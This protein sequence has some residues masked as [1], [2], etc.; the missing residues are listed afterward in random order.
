VAR[1]ALLL[2]LVV[3]AA[4]CGNGRHSGV[5]TASVATHAAASSTSG[6]TTATVPSSVTSTTAR[7][8][9]SA[10]AVW[11]GLGE[12]GG[13]AGSTFYPVELTNISSHACHLFGFPGVS[14][15]RGH[16]LGSPAQ[17]NHGVPKSTVTL[18]PGE[19]AHTVLQ[20]SDV[21]NFSRSQCAS[22]TAFGLKLIP[23]DETTS[24]GVPFSFR[25]CSKPG[26]VYLTVQPIQSGVGVPGYPNL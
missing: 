6:T 9:T 26:P 3:I 11:L 19:T 23:P 22:V 8:A 15:W 17:R 12:G 25:A 20:I 1:L 5:P 21:S 16:L 4:G 2:P 13:T 10:L 18:L 14:A 24:A 7:C